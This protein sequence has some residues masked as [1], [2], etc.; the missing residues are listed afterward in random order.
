MVFAATNTAAAVADCTLYTSSGLHAA[1]ASFFAATGRASEAI[2]LSSNTEA[3]ADASASAP[4]VCVANDRKV[5]A[6][7]L[8]A[9]AAVSVA[10]SLATEIS[11]DPCWDSKIV[12]LSYSPNTGVNSQ[13]EFKLIVQHSS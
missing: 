13:D 2:F 5:V 10:F 12:P 1:A 11:G 3:A 4:Y 7:R 6:A 8:A 9:T